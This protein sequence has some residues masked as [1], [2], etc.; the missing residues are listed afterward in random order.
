[1]TKGKIKRLKHCRFIRLLIMPVLFLLT[2]S[3]DSTTSPPGFQDD[4]VNGE[5]IGG[6][7]CK[8]MVSQSSLQD[9]ITNLQD[10][11]RDAESHLH[12]L[13]DEIPGFGGVY[14]DEHGNYSMLLTDLSQ[15][16]VASSVLK[17]NLRS[18]RTN[19]TQGVVF[20]QA[21]YTFRELA[22]WRELV[23]AF[24]LSNSEFKYVISN[25]VDESV[26]RIVVGIDEHDYNDHNINHVSKFLVNN[27]GIPLEAVIIEPDFQAVKDTELSFQNLSGETLD[28]QRPIVGG[29]RIRYG[30]SSRCTLGFLG[31]FEGIEVFVTN[32][33]CT[34]SSHQLSHTLYYQ[35][36]R[37][38]T[39]D[40]VGIEI[41]N[42]SQSIDACV[43][44][45]SDC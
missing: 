4:G 21:D 14:L 36:D 24:L 37:D 1:M 22:L 30:S 28:R 31:L 42:E 23:T 6:P 44:P 18:K 5:P 17:N 8:S 33:H 13:N 2:I 11:R 10:V 12:L 26:N 35:G 29:L 25:H 39:D 45:N 32:G 40:V 34:K 20:S 19:S 38:R 27:L 43:T 15:E 16:P 9:I 3:C 7:A 41:Q